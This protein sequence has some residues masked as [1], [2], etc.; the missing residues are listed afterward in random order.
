LNLSVN[1]YKLLLDRNNDLMASC[2]LGIMKLDTLG[3]MYYFKQIQSNLGLV[4]NLKKITVLKDSAGYYSFAFAWQAFETAGIGRFE[5]NEIL[6]TFSVQNAFNEYPQ[7]YSVN[8][9]WFYKSKYDESTYYSITSHSLGGPGG[10]GSFLSIRKHRNCNIIWNKKFG[11][12]ALPY[13]IT[14]FDEDKHKNI[15]FTKSALSMGYH[16][17]YSNDLIKLDSNGVHNNIKYTLINYSWWPPSAQ[18]EQ[19]ILQTLYDNNYF[20]TFVG[21]EFPSNPLSITILDSTLLSNCTSTASVTLLNELTGSMGTDTFLLKQ[22]ITPYILQDKAI[23]IAPILNFAVGPNYCTVLKLNENSDLK[24]EIKIYPNPS[25]N[26][27][28]IISSNYIEEISIYDINSKKVFG[29][30]TSAIIDV[31]SLHSG[32]YFIKVKTDQG[33]FSQ[34]FIKE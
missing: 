19:S 9:A 5:Y 20:Y 12:G 22:S 24:K 27:V 30:I 11:L 33:E 10:G 17:N 34:K 18:F 32:L 25:S 4:D 3:N 29:S 31:S 15:V 6:D 28:N 8:N 14:S 26:I 7:F 2:N 16:A 21:A 23:N 13:I 1:F